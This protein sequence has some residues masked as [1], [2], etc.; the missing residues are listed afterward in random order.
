MP[1]I[2][3]RKKYENFALVTYVLYLG[4]GLPYETDGD[5]R[6]L[7]EGCKFWILVSLRVFREKRQYFFAVWVSFRVP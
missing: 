6:R 7:P 2:S 5:A 3:S 4:G 1:A